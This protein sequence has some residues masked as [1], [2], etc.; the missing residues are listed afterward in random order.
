MQIFFIE[1]Q[2]FEGRGLQPAQ[3]NSS[4]ARCLNRSGSALFERERSIEELVQ[5]DSA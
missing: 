1:T 2:L 5:D 3:A 4:L